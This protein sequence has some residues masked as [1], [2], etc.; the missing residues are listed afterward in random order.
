MAY[1]SKQLTGAPANYPT[2]EC[3]LMAIVVAIK[4]WRHYVD[5]KCTRVVTNHEP[6]EASA[7]I[8]PVVQPP[9]A[10]AGIPANIQ[11]GI[12][13]PSGQGGPCA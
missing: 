3:E 11:A 4:K 2:H 5:G 6:L 12:C 13:V 9:S 7:D 1:Y 8:A 10:L